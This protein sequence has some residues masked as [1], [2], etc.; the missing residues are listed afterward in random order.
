MRTN[1]V[2]VFAFIILITAGACVDGDEVVVY[3]DATSTPSPTPAATAIESPTPSPEI[4]DDD[5]DSIVNAGDNCPDDSNP[6][7]MDSDADGEGDQCDEFTYLAPGHCVVRVPYE[8]KDVAGQI[9]EAGVAVSEVACCSID[10]D[11]F[12]NQ[13][14]RY[15]V[16]DAILAQATGEHTVAT[17]QPCIQAPTSRAPDR[18]QNIGCDDGYDCVWGMQDLLPDGHLEELL[19]EWSSLTGAPDQS[20]WWCE[21]S[22]VPPQPVLDPECADE[23]DYVLRPVYPEARAHLGSIVIDVDL[24]TPE[25]YTDVRLLEFEIHACKGLEIEGLFFWFHLY[26]LYP[27]AE[28][29]GDPKD[30]TGMIIGETPD[31]HW[32]TRFHDFTVW[33]NGEVVYY[34]E[35]AHEM[36]ISDEAASPQFRGPIRHLEPGDAIRFTFT[37]SVRPDN[38]PDEPYGFVTGLGHMGGVIFEGPPSPNPLGRFTP[39]D[40]DLTHPVPIRI[41]P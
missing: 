7:Q 5:G 41:I 29:E 3:M 31:G 30:A 38:P 17:C 39:Q 34:T 9:V 25:S 37:V 4:P 35:D 19:E 21:E 40:L 6:D 33:E 24:D 15:C 27:Q 32:L 13:N 16:L 8:I 22:P 28:N 10:N 14:G 2:S 36:S 11:C 26:D 18:S 1:S 20:V 12:G 23:I